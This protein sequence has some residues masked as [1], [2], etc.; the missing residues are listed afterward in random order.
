MVRQREGKAGTSR[1]Y[2]KSGWLED[3]LTANRAMAVMPSD[4]CL[5]CLVPYSRTRLPG[6]GAAAVGAMFSP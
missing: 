1:L 3:L 2:G 5:A 4:Y 6:R